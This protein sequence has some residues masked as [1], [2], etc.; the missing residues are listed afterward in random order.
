MG[1]STDVMGGDVHVGEARDEHSAP[2]PRGASE[3]HETRGPQGAGSPSDPSGASLVYDID[4]AVQFGS[5][6]TGQ[7][8]EVVF[9]ILCA[10]DRY[11]L[12]VGI[13]PEDENVG[14]K[15]AEIRRMH[16]DLF[17]VV[18][19]DNRRVVPRLEE[20]FILR[21][22]GVGADVVRRVMGADYQLMFR[23]GILV[24]VTGAKAPLVGGAVGQLA[25]TGAGKTADARP[26]AAQGAA[27]SHG[28]SEP[29]GIRARQEPTDVLQRTRAVR[30]DE[31][32]PDLR[33]L[34]RQRHPHVQG[35][36]SQM[37]LTST[38]TTARV[39]EADAGVDAEHT[40]S[41]PL[42]SLQTRVASPNGA[43][44]WSGGGKAPGAGGNRLEKPR[45]G[46]PCAG[47]SRRN[48]KTLGRRFP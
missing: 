41:V 7:D 33:L 13:V 47:L 18:H 44:A 4:E 15:A 23:L 22:S 21:D 16:P 30:T 6:A 1:R 2:P 26:V 8:P 39:E 28:A 45:E 20:E 38:A 37:T 34:L 43:W 3:L 32:L 5:E 42:V 27:V 9:A 31:G 25:T 14:P 19:M 36:P 11:L 12:G 40:P 24:G 46:V 10:R 48:V 17:P 35:K 29:H